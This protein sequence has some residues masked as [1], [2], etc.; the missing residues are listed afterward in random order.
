MARVKVVIMGAEK[1]V[2][3]H[4]TDLQACA[5]AKGLNRDDAELLDEL[6]LFC[7]SVLEGNPDAGLVE[8]TPENVVNILGA[9]HASTASAAPA[10]TAEAP[11]SVHD[12]GNSIAPAETGIR[13]QT[14][15][16]P[17]SPAA[18]SAVHDASKTIAPVDETK[19][20][21]LETE[22]PAGETAP[23]PSTVHDASSTVAPEGEGP[24]AAD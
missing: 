14:R 7:D 5:A 4:I 16:D 17:T 1:T 6:D 10:G 13:E 3:V 15:I 21:D 8:L 12:A 2:Q 11:I 22:A 20:A 9:D 18:V 24:A 23:V 19:P